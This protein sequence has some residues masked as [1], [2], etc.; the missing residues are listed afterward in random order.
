MSFTLRPL[1]SGSCYFSAYALLAYGI[2]WTFWLI[3]L[4]MP[5]TAIGSVAFYLGGFGP[6]SS[7]VVMI[8]WQG[9]KPLT[10]L[11]GLFRWRLQLHWY[12]F[13]LSF[14]AFLACIAMLIYLLAG[15][16]LDPTL[17]PKRLA[18]YVPILITMALIGGG[19]EEPGW[20]GFGLPVLQRQ[21][22]P[23][24]ATL[25]LGMVWAFWHL[26]LLAADPAL[27]AGGVNIV[28]LAPKVAL[29]LLSISCHAFWY[30]WLINRTGSVLLCVLLHGGYNTTNRLL[31]LIPEAEL[32]GEAEVVLLPIMTGVV[33]ASV[34]FLLLGTRGRLG[35]SSS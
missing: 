18:S 21:F 23:F 3:W 4:S 27:Q 29:L 30:T 25:I 14:P 17:L 8:W 20:R 1:P 15:Y 28:Q 7:A 32:H 24:Q 11:T 6:L 26:P 34:I 16:P 9:A 2:S 19:N 5:D 10:W 35:T 12:L 33:L 22:S 13:V 31:I